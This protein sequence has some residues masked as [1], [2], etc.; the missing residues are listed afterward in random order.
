[1]PRPKHLTDH[2]AG[3]AQAM[4]EQIIATVGGTHNSAFAQRVLAITLDGVRLGDRQNEMQKADS[5]F[6]DKEFIEGLST[7]RMLVNLGLDATGR[8]RQAPIARMS[9]SSFPIAL[10]SLLEQTMLQEYD[11]M[12]FA[13]HLDALNRAVSRRCSTD[14][15]FGTFCES[16]FYSV[17]LSDPGVNSRGSV[18]IAWSLRDRRLAATIHLGSRRF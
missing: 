5:T 3:E 11:G 6:Y 1:M 16:G 9:A 2:T 4:F 7:I 13:R 10:T 14:S 12:T 15:A 18:Q 8:K 17:R